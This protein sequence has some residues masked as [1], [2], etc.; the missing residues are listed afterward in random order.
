MPTKKRSFKLASAGRPSQKLALPAESYG[1]LT[2]QQAE[3]IV[4]ADARRSSN[5][6]LT[7]QSSFTGLNKGASEQIPDKLLT[8]ERL[9][10][11]REYSPRETSVLGNMVHL[12]RKWTNSA[13]YESR[14]R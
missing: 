14:K 9:G 8:V 6:T 1:T 10:V 12:S 13:R 5:K 7:T 2:Q 11:A 4:K 3:G